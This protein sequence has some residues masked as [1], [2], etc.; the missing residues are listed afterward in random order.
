[1]G[2][3]I[4]GGA[5]RWGDWLRTPAGRYAIG[6]EQAQFDAAVADAFGYFALQCGL[7]EIDCLREN[8]IQCRIHARL[9]DDRSDLP[10]TVG[11]TLTTVR[12]DSFEELPFGAQ[13]LDL[14][15]LPHVLEF[16]Q[17]PHQVLREIDR[18]LRPEGRLLVAGFNPISLWGARHALSGR[19][20]APALPHDGRLIAVPR[21]RD[22][23]GLLGFESDH[24][25]YGCYRPACASDRWLERW[26]FIE[27][28]GDRWWPICGSLYFLE[29]VK[30]VR[31]MRLIGPRVRR[32]AAKSAVPAVAASSR[33]QSSLSD[34][35]N[36]GSSAAD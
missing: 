15:A 36:R 4:I 5:T 17:D 25:R 16:A 3:S 23:L 18:V 19:A 31:G 8:R 1:M 11:S 21:L 28:A 7:P 22:W 29:S 34:T 24:A 32:A 35:C 13:T 10:G 2:R 14:V 12:I 6:W 26:R 20:L 27:R 30:R 33:S 9:A